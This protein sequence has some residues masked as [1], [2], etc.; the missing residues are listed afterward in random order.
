MVWIATAATRSEDLPHWHRALV[1]EPTD[2]GAMRPDIALHC[3]VAGSLA[4]F[5]FDTS[6]PHLSVHGSTRRFAVVRFLVAQGMTQIWPVGIPS[7]TSQPEP[8]TNEKIGELIPKV[9]DVLIDPLPWLPFS[10]PPS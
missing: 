2:E 1:L 6:H 9:Q 4:F 10:P 8:L 5:I 3:F 7:P